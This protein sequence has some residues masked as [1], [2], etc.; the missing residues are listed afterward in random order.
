M[1]ILINADTDGDGFIKYEEFIR[2]LLT[3]DNY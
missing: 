3:K 1:K 2:M